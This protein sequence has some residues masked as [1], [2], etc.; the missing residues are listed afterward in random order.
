MKL[1]EIIPIGIDVI[2]SKIFNEK[3]P[4]VIG[5]AIT[6]RCNYH[7][8]YCGRW[9]KQEKELSTKQ[10][11]S[12]I[13]QL[14]NLGCKKI[15][16]TGGEPLIREDIGDIINY[17]KKKGLLVGINSNG[18][19]IKNK[20]DIIKNIDY[21]TLSLD[22]PEKINDSTRVKGSYNKAIKAIEIAKNKNIKIS[23]TTVISKQNL[24]YLNK[25]LDISRKYKIFVYFQPVSFVYNNKSI[26]NFKP[27]VENYRKKIDELINLKKKKNNYVGNSIPGLKHLRNWPNS[28]KIKCASNIRFRI[29]P[30]G[31]IYICGRVIEMTKPQNSIKRGVRESLNT[32]T[33]FSCGNC[34]CARQVEINLAYSF[35]LKAITNIIRTF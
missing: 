35:N 16:F 5:W 30:N 31:N 1:N 33:N 18:S 29:E 9:K 8:K 19:L 26:K 2:K 11:F 27:F 13:D 23:L 32:I 12:I 20:I 6:N 28:K 7:C 34:W 15:V 25:V 21:L 4:L 3:I 24:N 10:V 22:G 14:A 17:C